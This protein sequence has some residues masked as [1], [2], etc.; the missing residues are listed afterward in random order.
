MA[1]RKSYQRGTVFKRAK[2]ECGWVAAGGSTVSPGTARR[3]VCAIKSTRHSHELHS[4]CEAQRCLDRDSPR[5]L[6]RQRAESKMKFRDFIE[7]AGQHVLPAYKLSTR[8]QYRYFMDRY[9]LPYFGE[10][11]LEDIRP[12]EVQRF[13]CLFPKLAPKTVRSMAAALSSSLRTAVN[14]GVLGD[15][16]RQGSC[17]T[18]LDV[19]CGNASAHYG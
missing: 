13:L 3:G 18:G 5:Q 11:M 4:R 17:P 2:K 9:L 19:R 7:G 12:D 6:G 8:L 10:W 14:L 15:K 1:R 16:P